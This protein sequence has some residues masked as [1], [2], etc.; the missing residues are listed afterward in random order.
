MAHTHPRNCSEFLLDFYK[1]INDLCN[2]LLKYMDCKPAICIF[3]NW[4]IQRIALIIVSIDSCTQVKGTIELYLFHTQIVFQGELSRTAESI[5][6]K[7][8]SFKKT[9]K[10]KTTT[11]KNTL[12]R[13]IKV[14][15]TS[16][17]KGMCQVH[18]RMAQNFFG[19]HQNGAVCRM[20]YRYFSILKSNI[21]QVCVSK[22]PN[23]ILTTVLCCIT[24]ILSQFCHIH[25][26]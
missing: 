25:L 8:P 14:N 22:I 5:H 7:T 23:H 1:I 21:S 12:T 3:K 9:P 10:T 13:R 18:T 6:Q 15:C 17:R 16:K 20:R 11:T 4:L 24:C 2:Q 26:K 19:I